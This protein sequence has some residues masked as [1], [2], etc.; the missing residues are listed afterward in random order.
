MNESQIIRR[1]DQIEE[2]TRQ[3][4]ELLTSDQDAVVVPGQGTWRRDMLEALWPRV[5]HLRGVRALFS[6]TAERASSVVA[7]PELVDRSQLSD[8]QQANEHARLSRLTRELFG[9]KTWPIEN[10]QSSRDGL[11]HYRMDKT[12]AGWWSEIT[13]ADR[14]GSDSATTSSALP[15]SAVTAHAGRWI[16]QSGDEIVVVGDSPTEVV[17]EL[18]R[19][20]R[21][22]AVWRVPASGAEADADLVA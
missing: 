1:L 7:F 21:K 14:T 9:Q 3:L 17:A 16:A 12:V 19:T 6:L 15:K 4:R 10:W 11:M 8:R 18:R 20:G 13:S 22:A 2:L 5:Q